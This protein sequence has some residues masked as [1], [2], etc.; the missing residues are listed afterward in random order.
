[1]SD[2]P[3]NRDLPSNLFRWLQGNLSELRETSQ[4]PLRV[5]QTWSSMFG[6]LSLKNLY[7]SPT[8]PKRLQAMADAGRI[9]RDA[10]EVAGISAQELANTLGLRDTS[11]IDEVERGEQ[12]LSLELIFRVASLIAR[13]DP[14]PF[15]LKFL[16]TYSPAFD[17]AL[18]RWGVASIPKWFERERRFANLFRARDELREF[19]DEEF[20][21]FIAYVE[22]ATDY[23]LE[24]MHRE[25]ALADGGEEADSPKP[26]AKNPPRKK[27][28]GKKKAAAKKTPP[29]RS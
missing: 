23:A 3:K 7:L 4:E 6:E 21:R 18:E 16:R 22:G 27:A 17:A 2:E 26:S 25:S 15:I 20:D 11:L 19:S 24:I 14:V 9:L 10:R 13:N 29:K 12:T 5:L 28:A 8:D 1:M